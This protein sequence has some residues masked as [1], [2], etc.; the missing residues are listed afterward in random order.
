MPLHSLFCSQGLYSPEDMQQIVE[1]ITELYAEG[2][3]RRGGSTPSKSIPEVSSRDRKHS[4]NKLTGIS[5]VP[6][7]YC[8]VNFVPSDN[9]FVANKKQDRFLRIVIHHLAAI[10]PQNAAG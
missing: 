6:D 8:V 10:W 5:T 1:K 7:F 3:L 9:L 2:R 4:M